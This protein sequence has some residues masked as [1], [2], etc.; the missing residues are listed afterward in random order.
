MS[1]SR[2]LKLLSKVVFAKKYSNNGESWSE[3][4]R[5][6]VDM[7][8]LKYPAEKDFIIKNFKHVE[9][10]LVLPSMRSLAN[11]SPQM[12]DNSIGMYNCAFTTLESCQDIMDAFVLMLRGTGVGLDVSG[13]SRIVLVGSSNIT[14]KLGLEDNEKSWIDT[15][16]LFLQ[17]L[18]STHTKW[19]IKDMS[20][21][22]SKDVNFNFADFHACCV[23][24]HHVF[25]NR[26]F[27]F[28]LPIDMFDIACHLAELANRSGVRRT[29]LLTLF[30]QHDKEMMNAKI[31]E[32]WNVNQNRSFSN[33]SVKMNRKSAN[34]EDYRKHV[35]NMFNSLSGE[36]GIFSTLLDMGTN[37]CGEISLENKQFC[38]LT[39]VSMKMIRSKDDFIERVR[40]AAYIG[41]LQAGYTDFPTLSGVWKETT[42]RD[43]LLGIGLTGIFD[44]NF[45]ITSDL[46][47]KARDAAIEENKNVAKRININPAARIFTIKPSG[48]A[49]CILETSSGIHNF[50][51]KYY[52]RRI[53]FNKDDPMINKLKEVVPELVEGINN[54]YEYALKIPVCIENFKKTTALDVLEKVDF[55]SKNWINRDKKGKECLSPKKTHNISCTVEFRPFEKK[56]CIDKMTSLFGHKKIKGITVLPKDDHTYKF[57]PFELISEEEFKRLDQFLSNVDLNM[58]NLNLN[59]NKDDSTE[60]GG[61]SC[62]IKKL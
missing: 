6:V 5:R 43:A 23:N 38:N 9:D 52:I 54:D 61:G 22:E 24:I 35:T 62:E 39:D 57:A 53:R 44:C 55:Y 48:T 49:S 4:V 27:E 37:P 18:F 46:L 56:E 47:L 45:K 50:F 19:Q 15:M 10:K 21:S 58:L 40:V 1:S 7:H 12:I 25:E 34:V 51:A 29:A 17:S 33:I 42:D 8:T 30:N 11:A 3:A 2:G 16:R 20:R 13:Y 26:N 59:T 60:C 41:T 32:W 31:G 36:P 14:I 28:L